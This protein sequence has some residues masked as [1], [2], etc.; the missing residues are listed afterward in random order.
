MGKYSEEVYEIVN[1]L[2]WNSLDKSLIERIDLSLPKI[3]NFDYPIWDEGYRHILERKIILRYLKKEI[4]SET[5]ALWQYFLM[6]RLNTIMPYYNQLYATQLSYDLSKEYEASETSSGNN[7]KNITGND[8]QNTTIE[9]NSNG[10]NTSDSTTTS[11]GSNTVSGTNQSKTVDSDTPQSAISE[12][13]DYAS[14]VSEVNSTL[15]NSTT[16]SG[17]ST[18]HNTGSNQNTQNGT[19]NTTKTSTSGETGSNS[20]SSS[21][22][23]HNNSLSRLIAE[24]RDVIINIDNLV[25]NDLNDLFIKIY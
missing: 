23:G 18:T 13:G 24:K 7:T 22:Y 19:N 9:N 21:R 4:C 20:T 17:S 14:F 1:S 25:L 3:F 10:S 8:T 16:N 6:E 2:T 11:S 12:G 5:F 15:G